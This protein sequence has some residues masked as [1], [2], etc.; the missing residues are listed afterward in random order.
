M[1]D[2]ISIIIP[3]RNEEDH[4]YSCLNSILNFKLP[5]NV[6]VEILV[7]DGKSTDETRDIV[8]SLIKLNENLSLYDNIGLIQSTA[9]NEGIRLSK[10]DYIMRLD[11][12]SY[13]PTDYLLNCFNISKK[14]GADNTGGFVI[15]VNLSD[16]FEAL[17][18]Q[19]LTTHRFGVGNS[20][21]RTSF[22]SR[23]T[24]TVPFGF[25]KKS[26]FQKIGFFD[27]RLIRCQDYEFN[28]RIVKNGGA[29]WLDSKIR[30]KYFNQTSIIAF[31]K[32]QLFKEAPFNPYMWYIAPYTFT[33]RHAVT[34]LFSAGVILGGILS[35]EFTHIKSVYLI[36]ILFYFSLSVISS[37][38][39]SIRYQS[40]MLFIVLPISFFSFHFLHGLGII[41]GIFR[42]IYGSS[43]VNINN[44]PWK[45]AIKFYLDKKSFI[46]LP[47][48]RFN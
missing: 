42:L 6:D 33:L 25:F 26:I 47:K 20:D 31:Y 29:I 35:Y 22:Q 13:Y 1:K 39:Q 23:F 48:F 8:N 34:G 37:I 14:Y 46:K 32:K 41:L 7:M 38:Q 4:I 12:H 15:S 36:T 11:A 3:C 9:L 5:D 40:L 16:K 44:S 28:Q 10:G 27:E 24:D 18:V 17:I 30:V 43:S 2:I 19:A 45:N 21:F